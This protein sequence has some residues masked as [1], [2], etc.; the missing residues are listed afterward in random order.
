MRVLVSDQSLVP[1]LQ[2]R[3]R[4]LQ[5]QIADV[6]DLDI[7]KEFL[8]ARVSVFAGTPEDIDVSRRHLDI[9]FLRKRKVL[10]LRG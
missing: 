10:D 5:D 3:A 2:T 7:G 9:G 1:K 6:I 8:P 4:K